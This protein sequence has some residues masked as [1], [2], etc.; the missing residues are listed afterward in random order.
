[1]ENE[2]GWL[3]GCLWDSVHP[4]EPS[5]DI[6]TPVTSSLIDI[7]DNVATYN[8]CYFTGSAAMFSSYPGPFLSS[9]SAL[10]FTFLNQAPTDSL[11]ASF[12]PPLT[13]HQ[14]LPQ[15]LCQEVGDFATACFRSG[16]YPVTVWRL[17]QEGVGRPRFMNAPWRMYEWILPI[18][19]A[20]K[21]EQSQAWRARGSPPPP[22]TSTRN[23]RHTTFVFLFYDLP[24]SCTSS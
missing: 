23:V 14:F 9:I 21:A 17:C 13:L 24:T 12:A 3:L 2:E 15:I 6:L 10:L 8:I 7:Y 20:V 11:P 1:M 19:R 5:T 16:L 18:I 4:R 22:P